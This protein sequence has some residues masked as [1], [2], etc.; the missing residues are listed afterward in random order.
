MHYA[1]LDVAIAEQIGVVLRNERTEGRRHRLRGFEQSAHGF[2][3]VARLD[4][5]GM[6]GG[7]HWWVTFLPSGEVGLGELRSL[8]TDGGI[9]GDNNATV[10]LLEIQRQ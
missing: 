4:V 8:T 10:G 7:P 6:E 3:H 2:G 9:D 1:L 5:T